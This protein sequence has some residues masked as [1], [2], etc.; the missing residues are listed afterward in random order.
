[1][2]NQAPLMASICSRG[3]DCLFEMCLQMEM[4]ARFVLLIM[5]CHIWVLL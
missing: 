5:I 3:S 1:M 2:G 4:Y